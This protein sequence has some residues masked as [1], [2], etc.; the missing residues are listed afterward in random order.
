MLL[1]RREDAEAYGTVE[2]DAG[3]RVT[4]FVEKKKASGQAYVNAGI[5]LAE[6]HI[7]EGS[8]G[9]FSLERDM[10]PKLLK[11][12]R[13]FGHPNLVSFEDIGTPERFLAFKRRIEG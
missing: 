3:W 5:C 7:F 8:T 10:L 4:G 2:V 6:K 1:A 11:G 12:G 13:V 9:V